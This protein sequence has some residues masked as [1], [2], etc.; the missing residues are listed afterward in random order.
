MTRKELY[1][2]I[3]RID[4][5]IEILD[6]LV[7]MPLCQCISHLG[8]FDEKFREENQIQL[9]H[10]I[11]VKDSLMLLGDK[12]DDVLNKIQHHPVSCY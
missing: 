5:C 12:P 2:D 8:S 6:G 7:T 10:L 9:Q 11:T 1:K 4:G 3:K